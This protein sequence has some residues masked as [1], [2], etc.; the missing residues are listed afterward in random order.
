M[1]KNKKLIKKSKKSGE[2]LVC[3]KLGH[4][5]TR[6]KNKAHPDC[7]MCWCCTE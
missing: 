7:G 4:T 5:F 1:R 6:G 3:E 2:Q